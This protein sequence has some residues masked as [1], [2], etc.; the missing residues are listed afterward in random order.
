[1]LSF[2]SVLNPCASNPCLQ[3]DCSPLPGDCSQ[4]TC[5]CDPC[6]QGPNCQTRKYKP[7]KSVAVLIVKTCICVNLIYVNIH[8]Q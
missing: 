5:S 1:M 7:I 8:G 6:F 2:L 3:G 4:Y